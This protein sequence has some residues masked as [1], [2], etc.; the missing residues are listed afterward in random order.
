MIKAWLRLV[1]P[2]IS[3][4]LMSFTRDHIDTSPPFFTTKTRI[5]KCCGHVIFL[6][7]IFWLD[8]IDIRTP[9]KNMEVERA[10][11]SRMSSKLT[12]K[13][14]SLKP[15]V[16]KEKFQKSGGALCLP[17]TFVEDSGNAEQNALFCRVFIQSSVKRLKWSFFSNMEFFYEKIFSQKEPHFRCLTGF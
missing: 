3:A 8:S 12:H 2:A 17:P 5:D 7:L 4:V 16:A 13:Q 9:N 11:I 1:F 6:C 10:T 14:I 15:S